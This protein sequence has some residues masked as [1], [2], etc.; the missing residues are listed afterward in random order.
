MFATRRRAHKQARQHRQE[1][2]IQQQIVRKLLAS[3]EFDTR[4]MSWPT[5]ADLDP[6]TESP[7]ISEHHRN[8]KKS[9]AHQSG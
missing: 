7:A 4:S 8:S 2:R 1:A 9:M 5:T 3:A 6:E